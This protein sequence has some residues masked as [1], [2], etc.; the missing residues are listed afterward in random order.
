MSLVVRL[1][2]RLISNWVYSKSEHKSR[3]LKQRVLESAKNFGKLGDTKVKYICAPKML[4]ANF[5]FVIKNFASTFTIFIIAQV[6][7]KT[8]KKAIIRLFNTK[9][10]VQILSQFEGGVQKCIA[11][12]VSTIFCIA[13]DRLTFDMWP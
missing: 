8:M 2:F 1:I 3:V 13:S 4:C 5:Y 11:L 7:S 10:S 6:Y 9:F 12:E